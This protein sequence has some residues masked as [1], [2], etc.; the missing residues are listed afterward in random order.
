MGEAKRRKRLDPQFGQVNEQKLFDEVIKQISLAVEQ[1]SVDGRSCYILLENQ[2][3]GYPLGVR[4]RVRKH[5][6]KQELP[7][8]LHIWLRPTDAA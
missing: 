6:E 5:L 1:A 3:Q 7:V 8:E 4:E 2:G